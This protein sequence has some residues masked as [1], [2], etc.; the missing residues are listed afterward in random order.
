MSRGEKYIEL[1]NYLKNCGLDTVEMTFQQVAD[2]TGGLPPA[3]YRYQSYWGDGSGGA[4]SFGWLNAGYS[5]RTK[6]RKRIVIFTEASKRALELLNMPGKLPLDAE[7]VVEKAEIYRKTYRDLRH[8]RHKSWEHCYSEFRACSSHPNETRR[9]RLSLYLAWYLASFGMLRGNSF[10][11]NHDH[12]IH[13]PLISKLMTSTFKPLHSEDISAEKSIALTLEAAEAIKS[14]Y[15][16]KPTNMLITK[17]LLGIFGTAPAYDYLFKRA[18]K[19]YD[20]C[21]GTFNRD[22]LE[23]LWAYYNRHRDRFEPVRESFSKDGILYTPMRVMDICLW[24]IGY[25][26]T[27]LQKKS[28]ATQ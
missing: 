20:V 19:K 21:G 3:A 5:A 1:T 26:E 6:F 24:Q 13:G 2:I 12:L 9:R 25:D 8:T 17:I 18:I 4:L 7:T 16:Q 10:L 23:S 14:A 27:E 11:I 15:P 22:S 28:R